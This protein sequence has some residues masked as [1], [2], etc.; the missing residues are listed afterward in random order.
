MSLTSNKAAELGKKSSR[1]GVPNR[2]TSEIRDSF[3]KLIE[4]KL[5][6][7]S[8]W[9]DEVAKDNPER[10]LNIIAKYAEFVLPKLHRKEISTTE[11][12]EQREMTKEERAKR[13][14]ELKEKLLNNNN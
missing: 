4:G 14:K 11:G 5:P 2:A 6:K 10:A 13:I 12:V 9:L 7:L 1:K 3:Q 8:E